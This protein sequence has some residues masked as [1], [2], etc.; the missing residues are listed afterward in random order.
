VCVAPL[1]AIQFFQAHILAI[2]YLFHVLRNDLK[3][4]F[5]AW[6]ADNENITHKYIAEMRRMARDETP[7]LSFV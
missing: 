7:F 6:C 5:L 4:T 3:V 2:I 1:F